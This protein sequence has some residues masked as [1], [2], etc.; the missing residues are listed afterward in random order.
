MKLIS[1]PGFACESLG[2]RQRNSA[3]G[4]IECNRIFRGERARS[5]ARAR[6]DL[7]ARNLRY[8][9]GRA[10]T[11][12]ARATFVIPDTLSLCSLYSG[13][14]TG[15]SAIEIDSARN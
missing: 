12:C 7:F 1:F 10:A 3:S 5:L 13:L 2:Q 4:V 11:V 6:S 8:N 9:E 15:S 14:E